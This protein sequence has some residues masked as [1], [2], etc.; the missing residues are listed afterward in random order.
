M[1]YAKAVKASAP[2]KLSQQYVKNLVHNLST[3]STTLQ[4]E[5]EPKSV[6]IVYIEV[7]EDHVSL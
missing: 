6:E 7:D 5:L 2:F 1:G 4:T 3:S